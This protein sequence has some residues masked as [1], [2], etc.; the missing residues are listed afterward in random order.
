MYVS[1]TITLS[2]I[3]CFHGNV[4]TLRLKLPIQKGLNKVKEKYFQ[5]FGSKCYLV[6]LEGL[7]PIISFLATYLFRVLPMNFILSCCER[8]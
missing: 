6:F 1:I 8:V 3:S 5:P 4:L 7:C 2:I